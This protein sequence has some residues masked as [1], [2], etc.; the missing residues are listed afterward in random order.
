MVSPQNLIKPRMTEYKATINGIDVHATYT[1][2]NIKEIFLPFLKTLA[3]LHERKGRRILVML[4]AP[5]GAGK[6]TLLDFLESLAKERAGIENIQTIGMDGFHRRQEFLIS[7]TTVRDGR[8]IPMV[9]VKGSPETFDLDKLK[10][11]IK[12]ISAGKTCGWPIYDRHLHNPV[13]DAIQVTGDIVILEGNY[14]LLDMEGWRDLSTYADY[15]VFIEADEELLKERLISRR[16]ASGH[17]REEAAPFVEYSDMYNARLCLEHS[18]KADLT[19]T[20]NP[21]NS[22][23]RI[24]PSLSERA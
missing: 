14:L 22:Y 6:S 10:E 19:L 1:E 23:S 12:T 15:T 9:E 20:I 5:P 16:I 24:D 18:K 17:P 8:E 2:E 7:H 4:A 13:E 21:D 11:G 3:G